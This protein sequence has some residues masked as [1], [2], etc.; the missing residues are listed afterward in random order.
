MDYE[1]RLSSEDIVGMD[2]TVDL[3]GA[4]MAVWKRTPAHENVDDDAV[5]EYFYDIAMRFTRGTIDHEGH[6]WPEQTD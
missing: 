5:F 3:A 4:K 1:F 2:G 6:R